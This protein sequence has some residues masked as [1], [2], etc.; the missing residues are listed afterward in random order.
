MTRATGRTP[1]GS[2]LAAKGL[3]RVAMQLPLAYHDVLRREAELYAVPRSSFMEM[4]LR[5]RR[6]M[7]D[8]RRP[9][10]APKYEYSFEAFERTELWAWYLKPDGKALLD[11][12]R[13]RSGKLTP[14]AWT[15]LVL[16]EWLGGP[17]TMRSPKSP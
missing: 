12:D 11:D 1:S 4:L 15:V 7:L 3:A 14:V 16:N 13:M 2:T 8:F 5:R 17:P 6:G 10:T 9:T